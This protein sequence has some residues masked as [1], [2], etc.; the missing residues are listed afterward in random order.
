[1]IGIE[2][3]IL[4]RLRACVHWKSTSDCEW[5]KRMLFL[6]AERLDLEYMRKMAKT[7]GTAVHL[8]EWIQQY[9]K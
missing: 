3:I 8:E 9:N 6:H 4:N 7:D 2:D 1:V 5:G